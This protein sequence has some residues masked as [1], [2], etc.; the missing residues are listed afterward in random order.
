MIK[1]K[2]NILDPKKIHIYTHEEEPQASFSFP[3]NLPDPRKTRNAPTRGEKKKRKLSSSSDSE[4]SFRSN[5]TSGSEGPSQNKEN[6]LIPEQEIS[7]YEKVRNENI[8]ERTS[9]FESL[10]IEAAKR[11]LG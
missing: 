1:N 5:S 3:T 7:Q 2:K 9:M 8:K 6:I 4:S 11:N 10:G